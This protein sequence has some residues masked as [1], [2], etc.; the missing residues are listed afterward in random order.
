[1]SKNKKNIL[2]ITYENYISNSIELSKY[3]IPELKQACRENKL[4]VTGKKS[5]LIDRITKLYN[6][7]KSSILIQKYLR[8]LFVIRWFKFKGPA[9][10]NRTLCNNTSDFITM[11]SI[12][13][14]PINN[15]ISIM[16][17]NKFIYGYDIISLIT[18]IIMHNKTKNPYTRD[19]FSKRTIEKI[20]RLFN[21]TCILFPDF[22]KENSKLI[23]KRERHPRSL[24][25]RNS[26]NII[27]LNANN[28]EYRPRYNPNAFRDGREDL[29]PIWNRINNIRRT[30]IQERIENLFMEIDLL[31]NYTQSSWFSQLTYN[32]YVR[33]Y[34]YLQ[35]IWNFRSNMSFETKIN[36]C[37]FYN[38]FDG[39]FPAGA[40]INQ[41]VIK[42]GCLIVFENFVYCGINEDYKKIGT[43]HA[44]SALTLVSENAR[45]ALPWLYESVSFAT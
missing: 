2:P 15:F 23:I 16:D 13:E 43:F 1:M 8:R 6:E 36:I 30:T 14:I 45:Q 31:G 19:K 24:L 28:Y 4:H 9:L 20:K 38:P 39:V 26:Y 29:I 40:E 33:F 5:I 7:T 3:K 32:Q 22:K 21:I 27:R 18:S 44:L 25:N 37:P 41:E 17:A 42:I 34:R 10:K 35:D 12:N 11:E